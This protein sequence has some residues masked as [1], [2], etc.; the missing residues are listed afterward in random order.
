MKQNEPWRHHYVPQLLLK[1]FAQADGMLWAYDSKNNKT[2]CAPPKDMA[3]EG[4]FYGNADIERW[5]AKQIDG[6]VGE[7]LGVLLAK[8]P[9]ST[10]QV[11]AFFMFV[12]AQMLR[13]PS[14]LQRLADSFA[15]QFQ[16]T[17]DRM[18]KY[19]TELRNNV[20]AGRK[21]AGDTDA[22]ISELVE[23][24]DNGAFKV[25]PA[26]EFTVWIAFDGLMRVAAEFVKMRW[27][28]L[29]VHPS[30]GDLI[31]GDHPVTLEDVAPKGTPA[32]PLGVKNPNIEIA[33]PISPRMVALAHWDGPISYGELAPGMADMLNERTLRNAHRFVYASFES[34]DLL[35]QAVSLRGTGPKTMTHRLRIGESLVM[36][37][38]FR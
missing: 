29:E 2:F 35:A 21:A 8:R 36:V 30:D 37:S 18:T 9:L 7:A 15:P 24:L 23:L 28:F 32:G 16:E 6:P 17:L 34:K 5:L 1:R 11:R 27:T 14:N 4:N 22:E 26:R 20:I 33:M 25:E 31:I 3:V 13:T 10:E 38:E 12:A 19:D